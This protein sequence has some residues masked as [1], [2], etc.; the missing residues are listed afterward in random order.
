MR[1]YTMT[2]RYDF[3]IHFVFSFLFSSIISLKIINS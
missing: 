2:P 1:R 3:P